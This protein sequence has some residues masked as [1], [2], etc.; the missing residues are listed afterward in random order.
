MVTSDLSDKPKKEIYFDTGD[1]FKLNNKKFL[2]I[3][4]RTKEIIKKGGNLIPLRQMSNILEN[5][6]NVNEAM[7][8]KLSMS[9]MVK[10]II[11]FTLQ[12]IKEKLK[13]LKN[14]SKIRFLI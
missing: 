9:F 8:K 11:C 3:I 6:P 14:G 13:I 1:V 2:K 10:I 5:H 4:G 12:K 7:A